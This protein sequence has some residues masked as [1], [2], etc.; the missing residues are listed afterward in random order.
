MTCIAFTTGYSAAAAPITAASHNGGGSSGVLV[1]RRHR[2]TLI[3][4][5]GYRE[6]GGTVLLNQGADRA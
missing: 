6:E 1:T 3:G 5:V 4:P 2:E